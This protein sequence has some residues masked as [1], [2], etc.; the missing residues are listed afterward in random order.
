M[1]V[2]VVCV[3]EVGLFGKVSLSEA[4]DV[5]EEVNLSCVEVEML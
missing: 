1:T 2:D 5:S 4:V 3:E